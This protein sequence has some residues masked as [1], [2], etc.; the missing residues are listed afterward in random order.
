VQ[1]RS[2]LATLRP[3]GW[4]IAALA[5]GALCRLWDLTGPSLFIDEGWTFH[6]AGGTTAQII[7]NT[8]YQDFHP[9]LFYLVTAWLMKR[10]RWA[11]WD[12][13]YLT[14]AFSL[15]GIAATWAIAKRFFGGTAAA[16]AAFAIAVQPALIEWDRLYRMYAVL[17]ALGAI[18]WWL[19]VRAADAQGRARVWWWAIYGISAIVLPYVQYVGALVV[20]S[21]AAYALADVRRRW[22]A[23]I[24]D[25]AA[26]IAL[27]PWAWALRV[28]FPH[29]GLVTQLNSPEF[30]W[31]TL[32]RATLAYGVPGAWLVH[33][34]FDLWFSAAALSVAIAGTIVARR[35]VVPF[36]L[37]P[38]LLHVIGSF[39][40]HKDLL[41]PRYLYVYVPAF[42][43][44]LGALVA[45]LG[46]TRYR[47]AGFAV[48][49]LYFGL[50][51][52]SVPNLILVPY[53][54]F[55]DWYQ[56]NAVVLQ[57]E[58][59][60]D[61]IVFDQG[62]EY[63]VVHD[64]S[65]FRGH[66]MDAPAI[67]TDVPRTIAWLASYPARRVWYIENQ[68][69]F[70]DARRRVKA[71]LDATRPLLRAWRQERVFKEDTVLMLL[72]GTRAAASGPKKAVKTTSP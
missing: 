63:W 26:A 42:C 56:V 72:Y 34:A 14:A 25:A 1:T 67:P 7:H 71:S 18:S 37:A 41:V 22:P 9:P 11:P 21:Q 35:S 19:L 59:R 3:Y 5:V 33:P 64:F 69:T 57:N 48:G 70:T 32:V 55:P 65:A 46:A 49:A 13:R 45:A 12:Y 58:H 61:I 29:G 50:A 51:A 38:I 2:P 31:P 62:A 24:G 43:L 23:L 36:W 6:I 10:L 28:Q 66:L 40:L 68:P 20:A 39:A 44:A 30:S 4:L 15:S 54:Q 60:D 47:V 8:A 27:L 53:Y 52:V 16:V 17:V